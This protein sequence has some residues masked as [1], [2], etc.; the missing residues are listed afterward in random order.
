MTLITALQVLIMTCANSN[1]YLEKRRVNTVDRVAIDSL[2][3]QYAFC[4]KAGGEKGR[5]RTFP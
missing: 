5:F 1:G 2:L 4:S 3:S